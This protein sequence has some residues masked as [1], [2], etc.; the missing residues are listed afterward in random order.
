MDKPRSRPFL[1]GFHS[2]SET[3]N[4][5]HGN[6]ALP[7]AVRKRHPYIQYQERTQNLSEVILAGRNQVCG[8]VPLFCVYRIPLLLSRICHVTL[9]HSGKPISGIN[10][11]GYR[12]IAHGHAGTKLLS[13]SSSMDFMIALQPFSV[14][15]IKA[16]FRHYR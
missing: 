6:Q 16:L 7:V 4:R 13:G 15:T 12:I 11:R 9:A 8:R 5:L 1:I 10:F 3:L 2:D 14:S